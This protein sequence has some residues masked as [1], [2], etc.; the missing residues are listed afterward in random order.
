MTENAQ[1]AAERPVWSTWTL[2]TATV[3]LALVALGDFLFYEHGAGINVAI[4]FVA[5]A[6]CIVALN[7][8]SLRKLSTLAYA[9]LALVLISPL[10]ETV[11]PMAWLSALGGVS[12]L[13]LAASGNLP[14][15]F[16]R[17]TEV[18]AR[19]GILAPIRL[20]RDGLV[21]L[22]E[23]GQRR[24]GG[25]LVR[26]LLVWVV[27]LIF[28]TVFIALFTLANPLLELGFHS[29]HLEWLMQLSPARIVG[30]G[31]LAVFV[32]PLLAPRLLV[33]RS[34]LPQQGPVA[35]KAESLVFGAAAI[36]NSLILF[37][38]LFA[39]QTLSDLAFLWSGVRLPDGITHADYAHRGAYPLIVTALLAAVFV[40]AAMHRGGAGEKA[41]FIRRLV[42]L[43]VAQNIWLIVSSILRLKLYVEVY[44]LSE[45]RIA[46]GIWM[47][48]VAIGLV[49]IVV[50]IAF[51]RTNMWLVTANLVALALTLYGVSWLNLPA[52]IA[53]YNVEH[54]REVTGQGV[55]LDMHYMSDLGAETIPAIDEFL[56]TAKYTSA[57]TLRDFSLLR[58]NMAEHYLD[59]DFRT[60]TGQV[61]P[62]EWQSW[63]WRLERLNQYL[64]GQPFAPDPV[65][66]IN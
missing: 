12:L 43:F 62:Y 22:S 41:A 7:P 64:L 13:A 23:A 65:D 56:M 53:T 57:T 30:W 20:A 51:N 46:A 9:A 60:G 4:F 38:A 50:R 8:A 17:L 29:I 54:S 27:P 24:F 34:P 42:Y 33:W 35:P 47:G 61:A 26:T 3:A 6:A 16:E 5:I 66:A 21:F 10:I 11:S 18:L 19:F 39:L 1:T 15:R 49:L 31:P 44:T 55:P 48:L 36:R 40:L 2:A 28:A 37:N 14:V 32:W 63:T 45:L 52:V 25:T 58:D 59:R